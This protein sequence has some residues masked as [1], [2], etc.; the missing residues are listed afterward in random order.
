M[1]NFLNYSMKKLQIFLVVIFTFN[2]NLIT[3]QLLKS[4]ID[5]INR[6]FAKNGF[7]IINE[8]KAK[9][10]GN[11]CMDV[12]MV[13]LNNIESKEGD[14]VIIFDSE[15]NAENFAKIYDT[16]SYEVLTNISERIHRKIIT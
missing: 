4:Q 12:F 14:E 16:I 7:I 13:N 11:I 3:S 1:G 9:I 5:G 8:K 2:I 15:N 6:G 10:I